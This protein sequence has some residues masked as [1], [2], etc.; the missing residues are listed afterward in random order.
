MKTPYLIQ[1]AEIEETRTDEMRFSQAVG[2]DYMFYKGGAV[3]KTS[4]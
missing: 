3:R 2:L 1:R 4:T